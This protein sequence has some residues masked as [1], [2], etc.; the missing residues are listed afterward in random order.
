MSYFPQFT[1][2]NE[3][4][5]SIVKVEVARDLITNSPLVPYWERQFQNQAVV[6]TVFHSTALEGNKL[7][8]AQTEDIIKGQSVQ[9]PRVRD[10]REIVNYRKAIGILSVAEEKQL[11]IGLIFKIHTVLGTG[12]LPDKY[13]GS[14]RKKNAVIMSSLTGDVV[15][16]PPPASEVETEMDD[17]IE[18]E[19]NN[20]S[21]IHPLI[22]AGIIHYELVRIHPFAD[23]NGRTARLMATWSL[24]RD[25][26]DIN[27]Y[28]SLEEYYDQNPKAYYNALDSANDGDLTGWLNYFCR[29][30]AEELQLVKEKVQEISKDRRF[31]TK[32]G[33]VSL[34]DRQIKI[35][36]IMEENSEFTNPDFAKYFP[37]VSDDTILRDLKDLI[38]KKVIIKKGKTKASKYV[39]V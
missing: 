21:T 26:F 14:F 27:K 12:V 34:N 17:L 22:K 37:K 4:L 18:W 24:Y 7:T 15:F 39:M 25:A 29:G 9:T 5:S 31:K 38:D 19:N 32:V 1:I 33:Q 23:L 30:V 20:S 35:I 6:R 8:Y 28:F 3:I 13:L 11:T 10:A 16:D 2:T 36:S